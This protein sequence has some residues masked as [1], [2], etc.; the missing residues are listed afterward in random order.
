MFAIIFMCIALLDELLFWMRCQQLRREAKEASE[1]LI[2]V[3]EELNYTDS[4][5]ESR[6]LV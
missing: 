2:V 1:R 5:Q 6:P 3:L 4:Q